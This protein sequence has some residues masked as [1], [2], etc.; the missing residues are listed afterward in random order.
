[1]LRH[2]QRASLH[3]VLREYQL[4]SSVL[5]A[6]VA[7]EAE[8][9]ALP[10]TPGECV[11]T[12]TRVNHAVA[13]LM[14][15]T[16]ETF[17]DLYTQTITD[18]AERLRQFTR[19]ATHEWR[20][21]LAPITTGVA[22]LRLAGLTD[23]QRH[24]VVDL[25]ARNAARLSDM[26][27]KLERVARLDGDVDTVALQTVSLTVV[28]TEAARQ[29][30]EMSEARAVRIDIAEDMP[31]LTVDLGRLELTLVNLLS[32]AI[33]YADP[34]KDDR[35]VAISARQLTSGACE[36]CV[37]DNGIGIPASRLNTIFS[38]F[39]RAHA[40]DPDFQSV[41]GMGL[42][43]AIVDDCV[44]ALGGTLAVQSKEGSGTQFCV[45]LPQHP[46]A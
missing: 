39:T 1:V 42:G 43:L 10:P 11:A 29:L 27:G 26:T 3:Q 21:P 35:F 40:D 16:V 38:R 15:D 33:K 5:L 22:L 13:V 17:V 9:M 28:A 41:A 12:T 34:D 44:K 7:D 45:T 18:Q 30:R 24:Q 8:R 32:N 23:E 2:R 36:I 20:Q 4:L 46:E 14:Q 31:S 6:F 19:M 37:A 25:I